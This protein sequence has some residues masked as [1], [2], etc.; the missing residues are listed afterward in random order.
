MSFFFCVSDVVG[1]REH[2]RDGVPVIGTVPGVFMRIP[3]PKPHRL[4]AS[5]PSQLC[6][7][8]ERHW[9]GLL[10]VHVGKADE[11]ARRAN[12]RNLHA[13]E[14]LDHSGV[15]IILVLDVL[16]GADLDVVHAAAQVH[17]L[18]IEMSSLT[19]CSGRPREGK[20]R[21]LLLILMSVS[22][23]EQFKVMLRTVRHSGA[24][25]L[26]SFV[27][28]VYRLAQDGIVS[29]TPQSSRRSGIPTSRLVAVYRHPQDGP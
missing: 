16:E 28:A 1:F 19:S 25:S 22:G 24:S 8:W 6:G 14:A 27:G 23:G 2:S 15:D 4:R 3:H 11:A 5:A 17:L 12:K 18:L 26:D 10:P 20:H 9:E 13:N 21:L 7:P 29:A